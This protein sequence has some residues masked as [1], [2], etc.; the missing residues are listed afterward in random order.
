MKTV[1]FQSYSDPGHGWVKVSHRL[2]AELNIAGLIT[3]YSYMRGEYAYLEEDC[4]LST[5]ILALERAGKQPEFVGHTNRNRQ[6]RIRSYQSY[7]D[8]SPVL[9]AVAQ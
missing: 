5:F 2:L 9:V 6:S 1:K 7:R 4:D 8:Q 3:P